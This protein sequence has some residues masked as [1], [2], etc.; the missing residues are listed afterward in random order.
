MKQLHSDVLSD[1]SESWVSLFSPRPK[2]C[3]KPQTEKHLVCAQAQ[4]D[5]RETPLQS[6]LPEDHA[7]PLEYIDRTPQHDIR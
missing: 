6:Q 1:H 3:G 2:G 4:W 7:F 5:P